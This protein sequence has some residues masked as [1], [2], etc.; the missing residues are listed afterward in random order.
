MHGDSMHGGLH[1]QAGTGGR[2]I[3]FMSCNTF[4][5]KAELLMFT[6]CLKIFINRQGQEAGIATFDSSHSKLQQLRSSS[7]SQSH[8]W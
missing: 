6:Q 8:V 3:A 2:Y 5:Q 7:P 4:F 1:T